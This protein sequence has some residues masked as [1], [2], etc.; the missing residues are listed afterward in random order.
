MNNVTHIIAIRRIDGTRV[1][2]KADPDHAL[3]RIAC[4][5]VFGIRHIKC[6]RIKHSKRENRA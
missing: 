1:R 3:T 5:R 4:E 6:V 2:I